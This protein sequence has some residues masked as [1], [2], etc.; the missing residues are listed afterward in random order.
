[1]SAHNYDII[2]DYVFATKCHTYMLGEKN[3]LQSSNRNER[4][5]VQIHNSNFE[6]E[7]IRGF[8]SNA[9]LLS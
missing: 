9:N 8:C 5:A 3:K 4:N 7:R 1:M 6:S 2:Y